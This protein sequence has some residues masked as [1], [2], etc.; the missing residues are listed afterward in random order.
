M[1]VLAAESAA[2]ESTSGAPVES[3]LWRAVTL[4]DYN[5]RVVLAGTCLLGLAGGVVGTFM[6]LRQRSL[7]AD[8]ASHAAF[9]GI[10]LA[11]LLAETFDPNV[12]SRM[13]VLGIRGDSAKAREFY[14][15]ARAMG[16]AQAG[17]RMEA[18]K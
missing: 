6:L 13:G 14:V 18:L 9:P 1:L 10:G 3:G 5:T 16:I 11:F 17:E 4:R 12:L 8:V 15:Q 7:E 2:A